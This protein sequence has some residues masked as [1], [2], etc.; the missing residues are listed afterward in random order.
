[1][2]IMK[3]L[4]ILIIALIGL[5]S[6]QS[7]QYEYFDPV[8]YV[9]P[10]PGDSTSFSLKVIPIFNESCVSCHKTGGIAPDLTPANAYND[11]FAKNQIDV[12]VPENSVLYKKMAAGGSMNKYTK[13]G[14]PE[15]VLQWIKEGAKNN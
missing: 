2:N 9:P 7:C 14:D 5:I 15:T 11:L 3:K 13:P 8:D 1:M 6:W 12:A 4:A 10:P